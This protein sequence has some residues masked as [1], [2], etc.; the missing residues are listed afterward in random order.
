VGETYSS[1]V[2]VVTPGREDDFVAAWKEFVG[3]SATMPGS[4]TFRLV[5]DRAQSNRFLSFAPWED[6]E[7]QHAWTQQP[8]FSDLLARTRA[9][10]DEFHPS[11][12]NAAAEVS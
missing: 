6:I 7:A 3:W 5:Q 10:C 8:E 9:H 4:G 11:E 1:A 12:Y 2:W